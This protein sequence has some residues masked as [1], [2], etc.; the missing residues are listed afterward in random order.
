[1]LKDYIE[2]TGGQSLIGSKDTTR[3]AF[4]KNLINDGEIWMEMIKNRNLTSHTNNKSTASSI[5]TNVSEKYVA[6]F[7][8]LQAKIDSLIS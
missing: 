4:N 5:V 3:L 7:L 1:M 2:F 8:E 6:C